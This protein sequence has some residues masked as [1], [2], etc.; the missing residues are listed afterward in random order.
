MKTLEDS[1]ALAKAMVDIG[2]HNGRRTAALITDMDVPL[3]HLV[4]NGLRCRRLP[5]R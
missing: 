3:G 4:G 5:K 1:I 2:E